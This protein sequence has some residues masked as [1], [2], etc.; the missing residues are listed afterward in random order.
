[1]HTGAD[2]DHF[3]ERLREVWSRR[4]WLAAS[5]FACAAAAGVTLA[6]TLPDVYRATATVLVEDPRVDYT[7]AAGLDRRL[8]LITQEILSRARLESVIYRFNLY[9][10]VRELASPEAAVH[11]MRRD[12]RTEVK[13][14]SFTGGAGGTI[15]LA[16]S[17]RGTDPGTV[18]RVVNA[19]AGFY[20]E[21]DRN[22]RER[23]AS[24][25]VRQLEAQLKSLKQTLDAQEREVAA[26]QQ[27]HLG[28][29]PQQSEANLAALEQLQTELRAI[30]EER[31]RA[32]DRRNDLLRRLAEIEDEAVAPTAAAPR[33]GPGRLEK[34][35]DELA[36]LQRRFSDRYPDVIRLKAEIAAL[37]SEPPPAEV[38]APAVEV[39]PAASSGRAAARL[40]ESLTEVE[41]QVEAFRSDE[42][43]LRSGIGGYL[44]R[45]ESAPR[46][47][48]AYQEISRDYQTTRD[49]YDALRKKYEQA[50]LDESA[51]GGDTG[52]RFRILDEAVVP[53]GP[54]APNRQLLL[55]LALLGAL[56]A[57]GAAAMLAERL[58]TSFKTADDIRAF[59]GVPV[60]TSIP[61]MDTAGDVKTRRLRF[62][63]TAVSV[64]LAIGL[65]IQASQI[66]ARDNDALVAMLSRGRS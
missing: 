4:K 18:T 3:T 31:M 55:M 32:L 61:R 13:A 65:L 26:F 60:L 6:M 40:Q 42:A 1:M 64:L 15:T 43:R 47:E 63:A 41:R 14:T 20:L 58:D 22:L 29:L 8:Q 21:Q 5:V 27:R 39:R 57:A 17:Y 44:Q 53:G 48:R 7:V 34:L 28:E 30:S 2:G 45:L 10:R 52:P 49:L 23:E 35:K 51:P 66:V 11:Q 12:V 16:V 25:T 19:L 62:L 38:P 59:T 56:A 36:D 9:P 37:E 33:A 50:Q 24:G 54:A 46:Q